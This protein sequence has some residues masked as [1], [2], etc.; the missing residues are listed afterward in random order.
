ML[1][2]QSRAPLVV[3]WVYVDRVDLAFVGVEQNLERV[4]VLG[5]DHDVE[6][7]VAAAL[8]FAGGQQAGVDR[9]AELGDDDQVFDGT[10]RHL[11]VGLG[12]LPPDEVGHPPAAGPANLVNT[13][14][15]T[16]HAM[17]LL[18]ALR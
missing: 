3:G 18:A 10:A 17:R 6:R 1:Y 12:V 4:K 7:A 14:Y 11:G 13:P 8:N 5:V 15:P 9:I 16:I 2:R